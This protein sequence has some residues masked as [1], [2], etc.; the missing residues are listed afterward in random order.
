MISIIAGTRTRSSFELE[1]P[2]VTNDGG[3]PILSY[4][5][6]EQFLNVNGEIIEV[7][8][9]FGSAPRSGVIDDLISGQEYTYLVKCSNLVGD[10]LY[11]P[12]FTF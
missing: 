11:S 8:K 7:V 5:L 3:S 1:W 12:A 2:A 4:T 6:I 10:S 9:Y